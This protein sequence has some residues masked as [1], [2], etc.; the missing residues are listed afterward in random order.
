MANQRGSR[1]ISRVRAG[2][3]MRKA[4]SDSSADTYISTRRCW[5]ADRTTFLKLLTSRLH[6]LRMGEDGP[7]HMDR[8][9]ADA[10]RC[11]SVPV[12]STRTVDAMPVAS[13]T[14]VPLALA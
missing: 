10:S 5:S 11:T 13:E 9:L 14:A 3:Q 6:L 12:K 2:D 4:D 7:L 1:A 8:G